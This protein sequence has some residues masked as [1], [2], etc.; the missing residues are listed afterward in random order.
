MAQQTIALGSSPNDGT[1]DD[2]RAGGDKINDN[3]TEVYASIAALQTSV[4][5]FTYAYNSGDTANSMAHAADETLTVGSLVRTRWY[6][7]NQDRYSN[8][9]YRVVSNNG[10]ENTT[11]VGDFANGGT[12]GAIIEG[13]W[14]RFAY[15]PD[16]GL[17]FPLRPLGVRCV[18]GV[19]G[20]HSRFATIVAFAKSQEIFLTG[21]G[22]L[23]CTET[24]L[25]DRAR[26]KRMPRFQGGTHAPNGATTGPSTFFTATCTNTAVTM[27]QANP[28]VVTMTSHGLAND[29]QIK[30]GVTPGG[31]LPGSL[32]VLTTYY[33]RNAAANTFEVSATAGGASISTAASAGSGT[34]YVF[35]GATQSNITTEDILRWDG[36][37]QRLGIVVRAALN[38]SN[39]DFMEH[40]LV[41]WG[42]GN[43]DRTTPPSCLCVRHEADDSPNGRYHYSANYGYVGV[44]V[45]GPAEK[46]SLTVRSIYQR[47][48]IYVLKGGS[49]DTLE[50]DLHA[51]NCQ[52]WYT[53]HDGV[54]TSVIV[55]F[56]C[57]SRDDP[58][59]DDSSEGDDA[60]AIFVR[61]GKSTDLNGFLRSNNG[62]RNVLVWGVN[63]N[64][65]AT[66]RVGADTVRFNLRMIH[67]YGIAV[68]IRAA[69]YVEGNIFTKDWDDTNGDLAGDVPCFIIG[70]VVNAGGL[71]VT[72]VAIKNAIGLKIGD[73]TSF[74]S[75]DGVGYYSYGADLGRW[76]IDMGTVIQF[77]PDG[78]ERSGGSAFPTTL[79]AVEIE[80]MKGG[81]ISFD[82]IRGNMVIDAGVTDT[83]TIIVPREMRRYTITKD[84]LSVCDVG[85]PTLLT[86]GLTIV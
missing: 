66:A 3:F 1:G 9:I 58:A 55:N 23:S 44:G 11:T 67:G 8:G 72:G 15:E 74:S 25:L 57:E 31:K 36:R 4:A 82:S 80:K 26:C 21:P 32:E 71:K 49:A 85:Y 20:W 34:F 63:N 56:H 65:G 68:E 17:T 29:A 52:A 28:G 48:A 39:K 41:V 12:S 83:A 2:L 47:H 16:D 84:I 62:K 79:T 73:A 18:E 64:S 69:R 19:T 77:N 81:T 33:V 13:S 42:D 45:Q 43:S 60:P 76:A 53:E 86:T 24:V 37:V 70:R 59:S 27:T 6:D 51:T 30:L 78:T 35:V 38:G 7:S 54:D 22:V 61:N 50:I 40:D 10:A 46:H 5:S 14:Y 75:A